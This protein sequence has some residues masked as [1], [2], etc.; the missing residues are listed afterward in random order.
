MNKRVQNFSSVSPDGLAY[1][2]VKP[3]EGAVMTNLKSH[4][5][6]WQIIYYSDV[7]LSAMASQISSP[8]IVYSTVYLGADKKTHPR[9]WP[10]LGEFA[11]DRWIP[12]TKGQ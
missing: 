4:I 10:F 5:H 6:A 1:E 8:T 12:R 11:G 3:F 7:I 2:F 9:H